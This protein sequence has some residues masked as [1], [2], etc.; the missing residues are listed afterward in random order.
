MDLVQKNLENF[1]KI[2]NLFLNFKGIF[3]IYFIACHIL[4]NTIKL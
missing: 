4:V 3:K 2:N 1:Y